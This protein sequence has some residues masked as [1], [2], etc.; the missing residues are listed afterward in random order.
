[1]P[2]LRVRHQAAR[3]EDPAELA[4]VAHL[5]RSRDRDVEVGEAFLD[6]LRE[7][8]RAD[9]VG[10]GFLRLLGLL[11]FGEDGDLRLLAGAVRQHQRASELLVGVA[12]VQPEPEVHLDGLVELGG[13]HLLEQANGLGRRVL[14][15]AVEER[16]GVPVVLTVRHLENVRFDAHG[17]GGARD[18]AHRLVDGSRVQVGHLRLG[19]LAHLVAG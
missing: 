12:D 4:D 1:M 6:T 8:G 9:H 7:V 14:L 3:A 2:G 10:A 17:L 5:I 13:L 19:D 11:A 15:L 16:L 18:D